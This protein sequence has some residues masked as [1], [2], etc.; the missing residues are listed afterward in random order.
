LL[1]SAE[2]TK[3]EKVLTIAFE[4]MDFLGSVTINSKYC[5]PIGNNGWY[6]RDGKMP[7]YDQ[8]AIDIMAMVLMYAQAHHMTNEPKYLKK[9]FLVYSWFLGENSLN[10]P[11][12][13]PETKG[14]YDGL[15]PYGVNLNQ[16]AE[17]TLAYMISHLAVL[18]A[19][20]TDPSFM[21][22]EAAME[23]VLLK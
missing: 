3:D 7:S 8:Q 1:H 21:Y 9:L 22:D 20:K 6:S 12:Y 11:L 4:S 15:H 17:S 13:D 10:I 18:Q 16:G 19:F 14:C 2:I 23:S 5:N